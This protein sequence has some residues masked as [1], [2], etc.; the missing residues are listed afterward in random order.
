M[1]KQTSKTKKILAS[2]LALGFILSACS[3]GQSADPSSESAASE[4]SA[5]ASST[6]ETGEEGS[7]ASSES[8]NEWYEG[9]NIEMAMI[10]YAGPSQEPHQ[11]YIVD[12]MEEKYPGLKIRLVPSESQDVVAQIKAAATNPPYDLMPNGEPPHLTMIAD[13]LL[14]PTDPD[15][16][17]NLK[18]IDPAFI[19]KSQGYG[20][21]VTYQL[22]GLAYNKDAVS[23]PPTDWSDMWKE[24]Y[25]GKI[26]LTPPSSNLGLGFLV[27]VAKQNGGSE[28]DLTP[29][30]DKIEELMPCVI[31]P[32]PTSLAQ[33]FEREEIVMAPLWATDAA[34]LADK[35]MN[36]GFVKP[37]SGAIAI[38]SC[39]S[40]IKNT[41]YPKLGDEILNMLCSE[42]YQTKAAA[43][44][45][46]FGPTNTKVQISDEAKEYIP[47]T[48]E[49]VASLQTIDWTKIVPQRAEILD[50]W[51]KKFTN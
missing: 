4:S 26:G 15:A 20:V 11:F 33:L 29:G 10:S 35:G 16:I 18:D 23:E 25:K 8:G 44:P 40:K 47:G 27:N 32:N 37:K 5:P 49:E 51:N 41:K 48:P 2:C 39:V 30:F 50:T 28:D 31:A 24:E 6:A 14:E 43:A 42:E 3:S 38:V 22:I 36:I 34:V 45:Y 12:P 7:A 21:P 17:P 13:G 46:F 19:E 9:A 1:K